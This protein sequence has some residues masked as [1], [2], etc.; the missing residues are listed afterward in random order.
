MRYRV[1]Q[2][3]PSDSPRQVRGLLASE[4]RLNTG[5]RVM[6]PLS[7]HVDQGEVFG[8]IGMAQ[9]GRSSL[10]AALAGEK[11]LTG[12]TLLFNGASSA[13]NRLEYQRQI[14]YCPRENPVITRLNSHEMLQ[15]IARLRGLPNDDIE[16][17]V[18]SIESKVG[19]R[20][21]LHESIDKLNLREC[22]SFCDRVGVLSSGEFQVI[23][24]TSLMKEGCQQRFTATMRLTP[25][26]VKEGDFFKTVNRVMKDKFPTSLISDIRM[27]MLQYTVKDVDI[28]WSDVFVRMEDIKEQLDLEDYVVCEASLADVFLGFS[29]ERKVVDF[30]GA[31]VRVYSMAE[32]CDIITEVPGT[33][34]MLGERGGVTQ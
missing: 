2:E 7:F 29:H 5:G 12:G 8:I 18:S 6:G 13:S 23:G 34:T 14:G 26:Q 31:E 22:D 10:L 27:D 16:Q 25:D 3:G 21:V 4:L 17:E 20:D 1:P 24:E 11:L 28:P 9:S 19:L 32:P 15:L 33:P 30:S